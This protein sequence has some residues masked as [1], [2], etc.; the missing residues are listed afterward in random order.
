MSYLYI[1]IWKVVQDMLLMEIKA[2]H[3]IICT[4]WSNLYST[5]LCTCTNSYVDT[6]IIYKYMGRCA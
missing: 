5:Y 3:R 4:I 2:S 6:E 1:T